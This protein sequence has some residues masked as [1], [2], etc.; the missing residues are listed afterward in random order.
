MPLCEDFPLHSMAFKNDM[1]LNS[2][3]INEDDLFELIIPEGCVMNKL[4]QPDN[5]SYDRNGAPEFKV[6]CCMLKEEIQ[7]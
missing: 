5:L 1:L 2:P 3:K 4:I 6:A 7:A